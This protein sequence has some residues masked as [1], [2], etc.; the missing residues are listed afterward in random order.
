M[1]VLPAI[2]LRGGRCVRLQQGRADRE[3]VYDGAPAAVA[4]SFAQAGAR[5]IH[6]V[7][8]DGAFDGAGRHLEVVR[9]LCSAVGPGTAIQLGGGLRTLEALAAALETGVGRVVAGTRACEDE[10]FVREAVA[11]F[12]GRFV[13][14]V[15]AREG[16][17]AVRGWVEDSG[18]EA[19]AL[20]RRLGE[21]GVSR[22]VFT[23]VATDGM[24]QGPNLAALRAVAD[25]PGCAVLAS[26][27]VGGPADLHSLA[28]LAAE[29]PRIEGVIVGK[30]L[31]DGRMTVAEAIAAAGPS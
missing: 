3:T 15:D 29:Y 23:D 16:R 24:L 2:D 21:L 22:V 13:V 31:H 14:G 9:A 5:W 30:A 28:A 27:G 12:G 8:L 19:V 11:A 20:V 17:V 7:D 26:G 10:G 6:V 18:R 25:G 1:T 4:A